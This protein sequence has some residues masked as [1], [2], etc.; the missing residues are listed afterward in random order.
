MQLAHDLDAPAAAESG[1]LCRCHDSLARAA[2]DVEKAETT[3]PFL[4][5]LAK[6][7]AMGTLQVG[8]EVIA[9]RAATFSAVALVADRTYCQVEALV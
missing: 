1:H 9:T 4:C 3:T 5:R 2:A 8:C 7:F 6:S